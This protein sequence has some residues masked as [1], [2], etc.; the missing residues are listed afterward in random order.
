MLGHLLSLKDIEFVDRAE[1]AA[2]IE[3][4]QR[5]AQ[6]LEELGVQDDPAE[7][8]QAAQAAREAFNAVNNGIEA[9]DKQREALLKLKTPGAVRHLTGML[10]AYDWEFV[11]QAKELRSYVVA[12]ILEETKHP[13]PRIRLKAL[14]MLGNVTEIGSFTERVEITKRDASEEELT[15]RLKER[16][17]AL[18]SPQNVVD[19]GPAAQ[20]PAAL[21]ASPEAPDDEV[22][23]IA[24]VRKGAA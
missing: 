1:P 17:Q 22:Q 24:V 7:E 14:Q 16:L 11:E 3:A 20:E 10:V 19:V 4:Q 15:K 13:D 18:L 12:K 21:V 6:W 8:H 2:V 9:T 23:Q 5:T